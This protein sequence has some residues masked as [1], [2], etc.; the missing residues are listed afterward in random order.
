MDR[1]ER[2]T[3][4]LPRKGWSAP[5]IQKTI[6][7]LQ[8]APAKKSEFVL[9]LDSAL[10][11]ILLGVAIFANFVISIALVPFLLVLT[12]VL[13]YTSLFFIGIVFGTMLDVVIRE[14]EF[15]QEKHFI[16]AEVLIPAVALINIYIITQLSNQLAVLLDTA[17]VGQQP[18]I[19]AVV[20]VVSFT[21][22]HLAYKYLHHRKYVPGILAA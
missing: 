20:Y 18:V 11:W 9:F 5:E 22:P 2:L 13:L 7:I 8:E 17:G 3:R 4:N 1:I 16:V 21:L 6:A 15:L 10:Y 12:G 19:V 14:T